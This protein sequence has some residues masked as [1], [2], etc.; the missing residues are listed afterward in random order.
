VHAR[1]CVWPLGGL[2]SG[3]VRFCWQPRCTAGG[4]LYAGGVWV[5]GGT[6]HSRRARPQEHWRGGVVNRSVR[7]SRPSSVDGLPPTCLLLFAQGCGPSFTGVWWHKAWQ[8]IA[9][10]YVHAYPRASARNDCVRSNGSDVADGGPVGLGLVCHLSSQPELHHDR[11]F[12]TALSAAL[13]SRLHSPPR[14]L[15]GGWRPGSDDQPPSTTLCVHRRGAGPRPHWSR[16][17]SHHPTLS[18]PADVGVWLDAN[19]ALS[20]TL[21]RPRR[22]SWSKK[23]ADLAVAAPCRWSNRLPSSW[24]L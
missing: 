1:R 17:V 23:P 15:I 3:V 7:H 2:Q 18:G 14:R 9:K 21:A 6:A 11:S 13:F 16:G 19:T 5:E 12:A 4:S 20:R 22:A 8:D 10:V 24:D